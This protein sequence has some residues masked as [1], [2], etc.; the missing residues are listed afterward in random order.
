MVLAEAMAHGT[1]FV[2]TETGG[3]AS[4]LGGNG[5]GRLLKPQASP[6][7]WAATIRSVMDDP[8]AYQFMSDACFERRQA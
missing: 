1:P 5:T 2:A 4:L 8:A 3:V 6:S 7:E